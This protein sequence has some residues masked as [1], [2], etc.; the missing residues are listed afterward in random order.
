MKLLYSALSV[1]A[2]TAAA[3]ELQAYVSK[4]DNG[5]K[6]NGLGKKANEE[7]ATVETLPFGPAR[8]PNEDMPLSTVV[9]LESGMLGSTTTYAPTYTPE[10]V[11]LN[12]YCLF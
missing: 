7:E 11:P 5:N 4:A 10:W 6:G 12:K 8:D 1:I 3:N 9:P 2:A